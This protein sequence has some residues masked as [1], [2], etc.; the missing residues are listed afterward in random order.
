MVTPAILWGLETVRL[1]EKEKG[2]ITTTHPE[3]ILRRLKPHK[4]GDEYV[5]DYSKQR[6]R[7]AAR[8]VREVAGRVEGAGR[9]EGKWWGNCKV[10]SI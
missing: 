7:T 9:W 2:K 8:W 6:N 5:E 10:S 3:M 4:Q 1:T